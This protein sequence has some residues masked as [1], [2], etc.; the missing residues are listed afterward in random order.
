MSR[1]LSSQTPLRLISERRRRWN[2]GDLG[3]C[4]KRLWKGQSPVQGEEVLTSGQLMLEVF[5]L[6]LRTTAGVDLHGLEQR[7]G[8]TFHTSFSRLRQKLEAQELERLVE[9]SGSRCRLTLEGQVFSD[10]VNAVFADG[11]G[12]TDNGRG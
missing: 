2:V 9:I 11:M 12:E 4:I 7:F 8:H 1:L 3:R 5:F 10:T 6:G